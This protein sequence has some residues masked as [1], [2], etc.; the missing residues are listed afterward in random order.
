MLGL[1]IEH[2]RRAGAKAKESGNQLLEKTGARGLIVRKDW[3]AVS[4]VAGAG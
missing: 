1:A 2:I 3:A 4:P